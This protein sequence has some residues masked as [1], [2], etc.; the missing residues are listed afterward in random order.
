MS[1]PLS[2]TNC[3][4]CLA[5]SATSPLA[6]GSWIQQLGHYHTSWML[7]HASSPGP[8]PGQPRAVSLIVRTGNVVL[9]L[10]QGMQMIH[11]AQ[12]TTPTQLGTRRRA[13]RSFTRLNL[14]PR[15]I[16]A[17]SPPR[18]PRQNQ[19]PTLQ[20]PQAPQPVPQ[21]INTHNPSL[22]YASM[23]H[24]Q[25]E[26]AE[27]G[28]EVQLAEEGRQDAA[29][30]LEVRLR[31]LYGTA[32]VGLCVRVS[33][34]LIRIIGAGKRP[35]PPPGPAMR[36]APATRTT[37]SALPTGHDAAG[38]PK[39]IPQRTTEHNPPPPL[40]NRTIQHRDSH[41]PQYARNYPQHPPIVSNALPACNAAKVSTRQYGTTFKP[42]YPPC[43][44]PHPVPRN[45]RVPPICHLNPQERPSNARRPAL[46]R[47]PQAP[48]LPLPRKC[49]LH[50]PATPLPVNP[51]GAGRTRA[52]SSS[53]WKG[54]TTA[55]LA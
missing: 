54:T 39:R 5:I 51:P 14:S 53:R 9:L 52:A 21:R 30:D 8:P 17:P 33:N 2:H 18:V 47:K 31:N 28:R 6:F 1:K 37:V 45:L 25:D 20:A 50:T 41:S 34:V 42:G 35:P 43:H 29:V 11:A 10:S 26:E 12:G 22:L 49:A 16:P 55:A 36:C 27:Q 38:S 7:Y 46:L 23:P 15:H 40:R 24:L 44:A 3:V 4:Q 13:H 32:H 19:A 48:A